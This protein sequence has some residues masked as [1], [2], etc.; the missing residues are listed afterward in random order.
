MAIPLRTIQQEIDD[1]IYRVKYKPRAQFL[2]FHMRSQRFACMVVH[3]RGGK[4][5]A[6]INEAVARAIY[7]KKEDARYA[8]IAP[9]R[10]QAKDLAWTYLRRFTD[11][12]TEKVSESELSVTFAH[13]KARIRI[14]GADNPESFRGIYLDGVI[15]DEYGDM[16]PIIW[17]QILL[18]TLMDRKGWA[19]FIGTFKGRNHFWKIYERSQGR[20][21]LANEDPGYF[22]KN[23]FSYLLPASKST[24]YT[25]AEFDAVRAETDEEEWQQE[26]ECNPDAA[27]K[28]TYYAKHISQL[29][30]VGQI[31]DDAAEFNPDLPV[32]IFS[33]IGRTDSCALWFY[34]RRAGGYALIDYEEFNGQGVDHYA[35]VVAN[36]PYAYECIWVPHDAKAK[37]LATKR[38]TIEQLVDYDNN[39]YFRRWDA[40]TALLRL[41]P[42]LAVQH[43]IDAVRAILP[44]CYF[45][46]KTEA[47]IEALRAYKRRWD[48][49]TKSFAD[50]PYH[51]WASHG[52][53]AFRYFALGVKD[54]KPPRVLVPDAPKIIL[55]PKICLEDLWAER[56]NSAYSRNRI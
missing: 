24:I 55:A 47:G 13:N 50:D 36:K 44:D 49:I 2:P 15:V 31:Y 30:A 8:Y 17:G 6:S 43:G 11:G 34:Q 41:S 33:D 12:I 35:S 1:G 51:D 4:T 7:T 20:S 28:G 27:V 32:G 54:F 14:Y 21:L 46:T 25:Q 3:R 56:A 40:G 9:F 39:G 23:W 29:Q 10:N 48:D 52:S 53:D 37:T 5:V 19:V 45:S 22:H 18:P 42:R 38:S 16:S 26:Y